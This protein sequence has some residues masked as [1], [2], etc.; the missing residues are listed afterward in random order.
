MTASPRAPFG[1]AF[2]RAI[3]SQPRPRKAQKENEMSP[4]NIRPGSN[5]PAILT[6][7]EAAK[8]AGMDGTHIRAALYN[9]E[10][11]IRVVEGRT[12]IRRV[13]LAAWL[14]GKGFKMLAGAQ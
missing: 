3:R 9:H 4:P 7:P 5:P 14:D 2:D 8:W 12:F 1:D 13:D 11:P 6:V 10:I